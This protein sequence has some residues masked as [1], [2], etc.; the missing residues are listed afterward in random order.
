[1][2]HVVW[3][4]R[5]SSKRHRVSSIE[6]RCESLHVFWAQRGSTI[7]WSRLVWIQKQ[8]LFAL[9]IKCSQKLDET[10]PKKWCRNIFGPLSF[11]R[12]N[13]A[14][15][16]LTCFLGESLKTCVKNGANLQRYSWHRGLFSG[17]AHLL[18]EGFHWLNKNGTRYRT[19]SS[20][21]ILSP[22][23]S[24][25]VGTRGKHLL[26]HCGSRGAFK[27]ANPVTKRQFSLNMRLSRPQVPLY[28]LKQVD[29]TNVGNQPS[30]NLSRSKSLPS[31]ADVAHW[32]HDWRPC[33]NHATPF[34]GHKCLKTNMPP[35]FFNKGEIPMNPPTPSP[36]RARNK[37]I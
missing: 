13:P 6:K 29:L 27:T 21:E 24:L 11:W 12:I 20:F 1:M 14:R 16:W 25:E 7:C 22:V 17:N 31:T 3:F 35:N 10:C 36:Q 8:V 4:W 30:Q 32:L 28:V 26:V 2:T 18:G 34:L 5:A 9:S 37:S 19:K 33:I 23:L 15:I